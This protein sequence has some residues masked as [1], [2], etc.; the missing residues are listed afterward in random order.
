MCAPRV[1]PR[2]FPHPSPAR[3]NRSGV[4]R[5]PAP[6]VLRDAS[7]PSPSQGRCRE[8]ESRHPLHVTPQVIPEGAGPVKGFA[9]SCLAVSGRW[10]HGEVGVRGQ[11]SDEV[12]PRRTAERPEG[13]EPGAVLDDDVGDGDSR[14]SW[15]SVWCLLLPSVGRGCAHQGRVGCAHQGR[16]ARFLAGPVGAAGHPFAATSWRHD[17]VRGA[18]TAGSIRKRDHA[19]GA[20]GGHDLHDPRRRGDLSALDRGQRPVTPFALGRG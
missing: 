9:G 18:W 3:T 7:S 11:G 20:C 4:R 13:L 6:A 14:L 12:R 2:R 17:G 10:W 5:L 16:V 1:P 15:D 8:F 19:C